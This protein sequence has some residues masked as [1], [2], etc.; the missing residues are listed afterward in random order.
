MTIVEKSTIFLSA[1]A[2]IATIWHSYKVRQ[3]FKLTVRPLL[4]ID[5]TT[6][7]SDD[8]RGIYLENNG[9]GPA[10]VKNF[11]V[12]LDDELIINGN[13]GSWWDITVKL[14]IDTE[15]VQVFKFRANDSIASNCR[16]YLYYFEGANKVHTSYSGFNH[17][18]KR[19]KIEV[20]Y[21]S[22]YKEKQ[23]VSVFEYSY[24]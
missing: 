7:S 22:I 21:E 18:L 17:S 13:N 12:Y 4:N 8:K 23:P 20:E 19:I 10:I 1:L 3:H 6:Y 15:F 16:Q 2:L 14:E 24:I 5:Y 11:F 9:V